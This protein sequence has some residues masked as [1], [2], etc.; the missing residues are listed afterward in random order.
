MQQQIGD[1]YNRYSLLGSKLHDRQSELDNMREEAKRHADSLK[2]L[3]TF[4][5]KIERQLPR[6]SAVPQNRDDAE[7]QLRSVKNVLED[8]YD[9]QPLLDGLR[10]QVWSYINCRMF[11]SHI[12]S[13]FIL[14]Y[15]L[16]SCYA[17]RVAYL[18][19]TCSKI[20]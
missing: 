17:G 13:I 14:N 3:A 4:L 15:R 5:D 18:A 8:M 20:S 2:S 9:K 16:Q 19:L 10:T 7:K 6:D 12:S 11:I 1:I